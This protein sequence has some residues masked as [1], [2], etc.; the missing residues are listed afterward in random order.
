MFVSNS[1]RWPNLWNYIGGPTGLPS[2]PMF[3]KRAEARQRLPAIGLSLVV[4]STVQGVLADPL[5]EQA[6]A[7][8][9]SAAHKYLASNP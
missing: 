8:S 7:G 1:I 4:G 2:H 6:A 3:G 9:S 5:T